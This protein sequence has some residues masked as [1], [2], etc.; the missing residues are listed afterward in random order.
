MTGIV[1]KRSIL[2]PVIVVAVVVILSIA[3][4]H[5][6]FEGHGRLIGKETAESYTALAEITPTGP[7]VNR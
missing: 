2:W 3:L 7:A 1:K 4:K 5:L 6:A